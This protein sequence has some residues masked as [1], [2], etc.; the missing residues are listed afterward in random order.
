MIK[1]EEIKHFYQLPEREMGLMI[2]KEYLQ[3]KILGW[4]FSSK[5]AGKLVFTGG[6]AIRIVYGGD[7]FS[8]DIDLDTDDL[9]WNEFEGI[10]EMVKRN[11]KREG[12]EVEVKNVN[13]GVM[14]SYLRFPKIMV[15]NGLSPN[16]NEK[17][18]IQLDMDKIKSW[19][20]TELKII[21]KFGVFEEVK[22]YDKQTLIKLKLEALVGRKRPKGR[23]IYDIVYLVTEGKLEKQVK[24]KL[25]KFCDDNDLEN[26]AKDVEP[27]VINR[28]K[29]KVVRKFRDWVGQN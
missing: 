19:G 22:I 25:L 26:L 8:E 11:F 16:K 2:L 9:G 23:D 3:Y 29:L 4:L 28:D 20:K 17:L 21:N 5:W 13:K 24:E 12:I 14:R 15:E 6:T 18:L 10:V 27:F 7:R 1:L